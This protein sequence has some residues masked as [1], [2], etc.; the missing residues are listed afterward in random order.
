[1]W[2]YRQ[3]LIAILISLW[4]E[5]AAHKLRTFCAL[6]VGWLSF[7]GLG[8]FLLEVSLSNSS[9]LHVPTPETWSPV[10]AW[11]YVGRMF[12]ADPWATLRWV[13]MTCIASACS[14]C[15][16][17]VLHRT[18]GMLLAY[19][20][21]RC[22]HAIAVCCYSVTAIIYLPQYATVFLLAMF[23]YTAALVTVIIPAGFFTTGSQS[24]VRLKSR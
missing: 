13:S 20:A 21:S 22:V 6:T 23:G 18:R 4:N 24:Q 16:V 5:V 14:G 10:L 15:L 7:I 12:Q 9:I 2:Y 3:V 11:D 1:V 19:F 17:A 8:L